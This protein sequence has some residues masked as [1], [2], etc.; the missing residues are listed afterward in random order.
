MGSVRYLEVQ[1]HVVGLYKHV[2]SLPS[3][4][5]SYRTL[6]SV[7][8]HELIINRTELRSQLQYT[9]TPYSP[10]ERRSPSSTPN[11]LYPGCPFANTTSSY[12]HNLVS[13][14]MTVPDCIPQI[15]YLRE[16]HMSGKPSKA[17][18]TT[19]A[20]TIH[21]DNYVP[22]ERECWWL[23]RSNVESL[24]PH[25]TRVHTGPRYCAYCRVF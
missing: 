21:T 15:R 20:L 14:S 25:G 17:P 7:I 5:Q 13:P 23:C 8:L 2:S 24:L 3:V 9:R 10:S 16:G 11:R 19:V 4:K 1:G 12:L 6:D 22:C 18:I